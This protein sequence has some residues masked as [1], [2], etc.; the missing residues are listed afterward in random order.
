MNTQPHI[1]TYSF[2]RIDIDGRTYT[3]DVII[4]PG[5]VQ[6]D[7]WRE[8]GHVLKPADL[9]AV[10]EAKP[11]VLVIGQGAYGRMQVPAATLAWL[12]EAGIEVVC[13]ETPQAVE[14]YNERCKG[15]RKIAA[16]MHLTC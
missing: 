9:P 6:A 14:A 16:A 2:G 10:L 1:N 8:Q 7:W 11:Q 12:Q 3:A 15:S 13:E 4:L 5:Q